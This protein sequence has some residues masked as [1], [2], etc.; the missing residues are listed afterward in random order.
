MKE[1]IVCTNSID[2]IIKKISSYDLCVHCLGR[3]FAAMGHGMSNRERGEKIR[4]CYK[5][6]LGENCWLCEGVMDDIEEFSELVIDALSEYEFESFLVGCRVEEDT[7]RKE[8]EIGRYTP[9][10]ESIKQEINREV[11]KL[12]ERKTKKIVE[13]VRPDITAI[14]DTS[15]NVIELDV[16]ALY[17]YGR[18]RKL[19]RGIPQTRWYCRKCRGVGCVFCGNTGK[20]YEESVEEIIAVRPVEVA[21]AHEEFFHGAG[22]EDIDV[23]M[24]GNGRPFILELRRP[25]KRNIDLSS[26]E[27]M[28]N[29]F[30]E[31]RVEVVQLSW[32][33]KKDIEKIKS[34]KWDK[35]Y[36]VII[37]TEEKGNI[38]ES[39]R[40]L[41]G[42]SL[43]QRT[44]FRVCHRRAD[45][46][47]V[48]KVRD[49]YIKEE[50]MDE[51]TL[52]VR[53][54]SGTYIK[55]LI[56]GDDGRTTPSLSEIAG[57][58]IEVKQLDVI[59]LGD[60]NGEKIE[61]Y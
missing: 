46:V 54:E 60:E 29:D 21:Q 42:C 28:V 55:E 4:E 39:V 57:C 14:V 34:A 37:K 56:T 26:L 40:A 7:L 12:V 22:R 20:M 50:K 5:L 31:G 19:A 24:L 3:Q 16:R 11:G 13:F 53:A 23:L 1:F 48:K 47:R 8:A 10:G 17:I 44:P 9:Y 49:I 45:R 25:K 33:Q 59:G 6:P 36:R 52:I 32:G 38:N 41:R 58:A 51:I 18:Y 30:G 61:G 2:E 27:K 43:N 35:I 15:Y